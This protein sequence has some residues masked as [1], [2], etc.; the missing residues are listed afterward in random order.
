MPIQLPPIMP[1]IV[2]PTAVSVAA[3]KGKR[4]VLILVGP[5]FDDP[6]LRKE[7]QALDG[8]RVQAAVRDVTMVVIVGDHIAGAADDAAAVRRHW[9]LP[10][11]HFAM[12]LIGKDGHEAFRTDNPVAAAVL[13]QTIDA[14]PMRRAG[15]R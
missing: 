1:V 3:M 5:A 14:M 11:D 2:A 4:R 8:W 13:T 15:Q 6:S 12:I 10:S 9:N 7:Q